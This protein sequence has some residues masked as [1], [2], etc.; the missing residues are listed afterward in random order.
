MRQVRARQIR[1]ALFN[2]LHE[3]EKKAGSWYERM[4]EKGTIECRGFR[5]L[6]RRAKKAYVAAR[7]REA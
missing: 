3:D 2:Q 5:R 4:N 7:R 1:K 6:Y